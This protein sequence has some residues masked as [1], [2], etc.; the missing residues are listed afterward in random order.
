MQRVPGSV[1]GVVCYGAVVSMPSSSSAPGVPALS[2]ALV[3]ALEA[4]VCVS[5]GGFI[6]NVKE[7]EINLLFLKC[8]FL[9]FM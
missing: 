9:H 6:D 1:R 7:T 5:D 3:A 8:T 4:C 2:E